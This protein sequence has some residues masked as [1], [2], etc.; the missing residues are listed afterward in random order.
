VKIVEQIVLDTH[1]HVPSIEE[2]R[3]VLDL[4]LS[5]LG[6]TWESYSR[7][8]A[9]I[10]AEFASISDADWNAGRGTWLESM[11]NRK[12]LFWTD[13]GA[14]LEPEAFANLQRDLTE[15]REGR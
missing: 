10:R 7:N 11:L 14:P 3:K 9:N 12:R 2:S 4:D 5:T 1:G 15:L 13:W 6:G 8:G